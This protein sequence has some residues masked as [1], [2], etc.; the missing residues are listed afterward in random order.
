MGGVKDCYLKREDAG[1]QH[2]GRCAACLNPLSKE[3]GVSCP[4]FDFSSFGEVE[5]AI[6]KKKVED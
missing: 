3:F 4:Y 5:E 2:V 1:N 6:M